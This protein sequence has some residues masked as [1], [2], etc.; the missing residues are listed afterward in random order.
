MALPDPNNITYNP[1]DIVTVFFQGHMASRIQAANYAG[2]KGLHVYTSETDIEHIYSPTS[3]TI[4]HNIYTTK[5]LNDIG[6]G[7]TLNP[8]Q[9]VSKIKSLVAN[10]YYDVYGASICH[11]YVTESN[12]AGP[13]DVQQNIK[14][15]E[16]C[17]KDYPNKKIVL[18]GCSRGAATVV[19]T[20]A[21]LNKDLLGHVVLAIV[22]APFDSVES[23]V[24]ASS[25]IPSLGMF[26]LRTFTKYEDKQQ[27]PLDAVN[28]DFPLDI[29]IAFVT[30]KADDRVPVE[31]TQRLI[32]VLNA[33]GH[34]NLHH[35]MLDDKH[36]SLMFMDDK[37]VEFV[38]G[39][40]EMYVK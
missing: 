21:N 36:H 40:Y 1:D 19:T 12:L 35:L 13:S 28:G 9:L 29:P 18:F 16:K 4:L 30:S 2:P 24:S 33:K 38:N 22:E 31:N 8:L 32:N 10:T 11:N 6:Y 20:L 3:P 23:V 5:D 26:Y 15:I 34:K 7:F 25:Y 14:T 27:S 37:Y 39:L 17:V